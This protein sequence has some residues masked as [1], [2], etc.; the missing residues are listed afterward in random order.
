MNTVQKSSLRL[1]SRQSHQNNSK[2]PLTVDHEGTGPLAPHAQ[3]LAWEWQRQVLLHGPT[4]PV[5]NFYEAK[6]YLTHSS[7]VPQISIFEVF[8][9]PSAHC[10]P[11]GR[12]GQRGLWDWGAVK[13][14]Q[15]SQRSES[16]RAVTLWTRVDFC[17]RLLL[18]CFNHNITSN[19][20]S[21][22]VK[23]INILL[24]WRWDSVSEISRTL[25]GNTWT[26]CI[27]HIW[28]VLF[29]HSVFSKENVM[30]KRAKGYNGQRPPSDA[31]VQTLTIT[32]QRRRNAGTYDCTPLH[33]SLIYCFTGSDLQ[34]CSCSRTSVW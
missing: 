33:L 25:Q 23:D 24:Q 15:H 8:Y 9:K 27:L 6:H 29:K 5:S 2:C 21:S 34:M 16:E 10:G 1:K 18:K 3:R 14:L 11:S 13:L 31:C 30:L 22:R 7:A 4:L 12:L 19:Q 28:T 17:D 32:K 26:G 20:T